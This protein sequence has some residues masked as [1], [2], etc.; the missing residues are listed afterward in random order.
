MRLRL[1]LLSLLSQLVLRTSAEHGD[2]VPILAAVACINWSDRHL[3]PAGNWGDSQ[4]Y[5][6]RHKLTFDQ[7]RYQWLV[8][9]WMLQGRS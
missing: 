8:I 6:F 1:A 4:S 9:C 2:H 3:F 7:S 5:D